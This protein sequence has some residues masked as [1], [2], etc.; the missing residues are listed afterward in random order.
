MGFILT[1]AS[2]IVCPHGGTIQYSAKRLATHF[3]DNSPIWV[4]DDSFSIAGC[5]K[6]KFRC[7]RVE[8]QWGS[9]TLFINSSAVLTT[10]SVGNCYDSG[11]GD[12]K[13]VV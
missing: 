12:R 10:D 11:S 7:E 9:P 8:W 3:I 6:G 5:P 1:S 4:I 13:S 2:S